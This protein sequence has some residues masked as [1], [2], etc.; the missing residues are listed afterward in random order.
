MRGLRRNFAYF[1]Q[2]AD[3]RASVYIS[4]SSLSEKKRAKLVNRARALG[5]INEYLMPAAG[6][7][8]AA[9]AFQLSCDLNA[10][11]QV[12]VLQLHCA[13]DSDSLGSATTTAT[14]D[15]S[16]LY[17][18]AELWAYARCLG[19]TQCTPYSPLGQ[20]G[21]AWEDT[22][23]FPTKW[24]DLPADAQL[25]LTVW[26]VT[27]GLCGRHCRAGATFRLFS[28]KGRIKV[29][30]H[31]LQLHA[32]QPADPG[33]P[34]Q[35]PA[36]LPLV[37]RGE[38]GRLEH[39]QRLYE[40][41]E[42]SQIPWLDPL[43][44]DH[45]E[46]LRSSDKGE[47]PNMRMRLDIEL[48]SFP[49]AVL[50]HAAAAAP[51][52]GALSEPLAEAHIKAPWIALQDS[53]MGRENPAEHKAQK[54]ARSVTRGLVDRALKPDTE[55]KRFINE[56]LHYPPNR[57]LTGEERALVW[58]F[59][60]SLVGEP[61]ALTRV[62]QC[63][64][65]SD[66]L[67]ARQAGELMTTWAPIA[68]AQAL[69]L[70]SPAF[71]QPEVRG[72][73]VSVLQRTD[74]EELLCYLLQL[75][76]ALR[77]EAADDSP[78]ASLLVARARTNSSLAIQL[79]WYLFVDWEDPV[80]GLRAAYVHRRLQAEADEAMED[81]SKQMGMV[82]QL[83]HISKGLKEMGRNAARKTDRLREMMSST[84]PCSE[85]GNLKCPLPLDPSVHVLGVM[86]QECSVFKSALAPLR[87]T[88]H[89][90]DTG[91]QTQ[92]PEME[93][94][95]EEA[96]PHSSMTGPG[97]DR[98]VMI[99][100]LGD[101]LRQ[102][103]LVLQLFSLMDR[104]LKR[105]HLDLRLTPYRVLPTNVDDGLMECILPSTALAKV[106]EEHRSIHRYL[107]QFHPDPSSPFGVKAEVLDTFVRSCAGYC[108]MTYIL[109][110]GD[111]HL[112]N[113]LLTPDGRLFHIDFGFILGTDPKP[114]PPPVKLCGEMV[115]A[116]GGADSPAYRRFCSLAC[117]AYN[118][119]RKSASLLLSLAHLMAGSSI[120]DIHAAP[121][122]A[123]LKLQE[124]LRLDLDDESAAEWM[125]QLLNES[126]TALM[127][128]IME[129]THRWAQYWR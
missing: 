66:A 127:P 110:V 32:G 46:N 42:V 81:I 94:A 101:D 92:P 79:H 104:L 49:N 67:E 122:T 126:A 14:P 115:D 99:Y 57:S 93:L 22:L 118:I 102:D 19:L 55:E 124:K 100:K 114:F 90:A 95:G 105:E 16:S 43:T 37:Q 77:Y 36:K 9:F 59:R 50:Y 10:E 41:G 113:L 4:T 47:G 5:P 15:N 45:I 39:L 63:V 6:P 27:V 74:D 112:D 13:A 116:M 98:Y 72:H 65:W 24:R 129:T 31:T 128:Q 111:R 26:E 38:L 21:C 97:K 62:L 3:L 17:V 121:E 52:T 28:R 91:E 33:W 106:L 44:L 85:L 107:A 69:E 71:P 125:Q 84:G 103:Q 123:L 68:A 1:A 51:A 11:V 83:R 48:P 35:T 29:A 20:A 34:S 80:F 7:N 56:I 89:T 75:V 54:M 78:L 12:K 23:T 88:L 109:G 108:V 86:P 76:Q 40:R 73:A 96:S 8:P 64:D 18:E 25:A 119:L 53:E 60:W 61:A 70:L 58:R 2:V 117:E 87:I 30:R 120:P 82:A